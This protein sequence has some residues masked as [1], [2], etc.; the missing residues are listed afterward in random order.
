GLRLSVRWDSTEFLPRRIRLAW[1]RS[2]FGPLAESQNLDET[3]RHYTRAC[4]L[5]LICGARGSLHPAQK[6]K[7]AAHDASHGL[8]APFAAGQRHHLHGS[9]RWTSA[10]LLLL[11]W[12]RRAALWSG[13]RFQGIAVPRSSRHR[14]SSQNM[15]F[16]SRDLSGRPAEHGANVWIEP[17]HPGMG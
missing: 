1:Y 12:Q 10:Q 2:S 13:S 14:D 4:H 9:R 15:D 6:S 16:P 17:Q 7:K 3:P 5:Q 11:P 8:D